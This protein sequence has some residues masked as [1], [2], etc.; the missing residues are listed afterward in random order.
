MLNKN[1]SL[2]RLRDGRR[3]FIFIMIVVITVAAINLSIGLTSQVLGSG[4]PGFEIITVADGDTLW[5]ITTEHFKS[6][7]IREII[8]DIKKLNGLKDSS[9]I[10]GQQLKIP[11]R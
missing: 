10:A 2:L 11:Y 5:E 9:L 7:D 6:G 8:Y 3:F 4:E 1:S